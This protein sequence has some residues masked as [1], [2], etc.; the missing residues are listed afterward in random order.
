MGIGRSRREYVNYPVR[1]LADPLLSSK[2]G[3][4]TNDDSNS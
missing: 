4:L 2:L 3:T 1:F